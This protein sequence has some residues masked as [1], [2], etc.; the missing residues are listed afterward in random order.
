[1]LHP[2]AVSASELGTQQTVKVVTE[3]VIGGLEST[4]WVVLV[5]G[6][7]VAVLGIVGAL[8]TGRR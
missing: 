1:M 2:N 3:D 4:A 7:V 8:V 5:A 6:L